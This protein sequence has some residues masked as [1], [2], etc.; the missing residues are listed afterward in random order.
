MHGKVLN[1][2]TVG[3]VSSM[4]MRGRATAEEI[5]RGLRKEKNVFG[6]SLVQ[7]FRDT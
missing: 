5:K 3:V 2:A 4:D 6:A 7:L 1:R